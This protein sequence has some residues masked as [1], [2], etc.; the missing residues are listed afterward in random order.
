MVHDDYYSQIHNNASTNSDKPIQATKKILVK[1][2]KVSKPSNTSSKDGLSIDVH[3]QEKKHQSN[4]ITQKTDSQDLENSQR[5]QS[6]SLNDVLDKKKSWGFRVVSS[7]VKDEVTSDVPKSNKSENLDT[8]DKKSQST[9]SKFKTPPASL[10]NFKKKSKELKVDDGDKNYR[11]KK[12]WFWKGPGSKKRIRNLDDID[13]DTFKRSSKSKPKKKAEKNVEDIEQTLKSKAWQ[14]IQVDETLTLKE[15]S[16]KIGIPLSSLIAEFMKNGMM[17]N[18]NSQI[19]FDTASLI[20]ETFEV[21]LEKK[22]SADVSISDI[23]LWD[24]S[25]LLKE[26]NISKLKERPPVVS[27]MWHVDHGKTSL[28]DYIRKESIAASEAGGITQ[29]I[30]AYQVDCDGKKISFLDTPGHEAFT[31]MRARGAK[32]TDIAIL[33]V[34]ADEWV[35]PQTLE[36]ISHAREADIAILVAINK[37][38][39]EWA[40]PDYVKWQLSEAGLTPE[41]WGGDTPMIPVSAHTWFWIDEL[42]EMI[43]LVSEMKQLQANPDRQVVWTVIESHL[44][45]SLWPVA[46]ILINTGTIKKWD[47]VVC[48]KSYGK[49]KLMKDYAGVWIIKALPW[50]P[51]LIVWLS[52][53]VD[54]GDILQWVE[55]IDIAKEKAYAFSE[56]LS[57]EKKAWISQLDLLMSRIQSWDLQQLKVVLKADTNWSLEAV[58]NAI[59][60]LSTNDTNVSI[61]HSGVGN[62]TEWDVLMCWWSSAILIWFWVQIWSNAKKALEQEKVEFIESKIIYHITEKLE[63]IITGM[64]N[65]TEQ[66]VFLCNAY[67][68]WIFYDS[69][70][71]KIIWLQWIKEWESIENNANIR[72]YRS[73]T[74]VGSW[75]IESLKFGVEEVKRLDWPTECWIK[76]SWISDILENDRVEVYKIISA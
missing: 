47:S 71:F 63:K 68:W 62:I 56:Y 35:K 43:T 1:K 51:V 70:K 31:I 26:E 19:D 61:I 10:W 53:V 13:R 52:E 69:R 50:D 67:V 20:A 8:Y 30:G 40:N 45:P 37:M 36:S 12:T 2:K 73:D 33:V 16:E 15:F 66:E 14:V 44:D 32:S 29:S 57:L 5:N 9:T 38:D 41:D 6:K 55:T 42:L 46:T 4:E 60:K 59:L 17:V 27:I 24:I 58:K 18:L 7:H 48:W 65:P 23:V 22:L 76:V 39:K 28:L 11:N 25:E 54:G 34:A 75:K 3:E 64:Y 49:I 21:V 74:I 72:I